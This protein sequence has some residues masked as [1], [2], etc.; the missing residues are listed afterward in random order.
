MKTVIFIIKLLIIFEKISNSW[1]Y[2]FQ[3]DLLKLIITEKFI[4]L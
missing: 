1:F 3:Y 4:H 2:I